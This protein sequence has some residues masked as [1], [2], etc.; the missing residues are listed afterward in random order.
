MFKLIALLYVI[1]APTLMGVCVAVALV[2]EDLTTGTG[3]SAAA[4]IGALLAVPAAWQ[5]ARAIRG[6][7]AV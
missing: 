2:V 3:V 4:A 6:R 1:I 5:V 7:Q